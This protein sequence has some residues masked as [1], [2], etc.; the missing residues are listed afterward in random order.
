VKL[1]EAFCKLFRWSR[2]HLSL[3]Y[4]FSYRAL[5]VLYISNLNPSGNTSFQVFQFLSQ[6]KDHADR[7]KTPNIAVKRWKA[8]C[9]QLMCKGC[10]HWMTIQMGLTIMV[11]LQILSDFTGPCLWFAKPASCSLSMSH[12]SI[13]G[14]RSRFVRA[15]GQIIKSQA[16]D[17]L[18]ESVKSL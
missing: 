3:A 8:N 10:V 16:R 9:A 12:V 11:D 13:C 15:A 17:V 18:L 7:P 4:W 5:L 6:I 1:K 14:E 2:F